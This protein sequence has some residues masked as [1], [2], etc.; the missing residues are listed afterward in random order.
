MEFYTNVLQWGN[1]ILYRGIKDNRRILEKVPFGP[2]LFFKSQAQESEHGSLFGEPLEPIKFGDI[3]DAKEYLKKYG[4]VQGFPIFGNTNFAYQFISEKYKKNIEF[5]QSKIKIRTID[6]ETSTE[7]GFPDVRN[8]AEEILLI[9]IQDYYTKELITY[10]VKPTKTE[11]TRYIACKDERDLLNRFINDFQADYP[12]VI[13]GWNIE[14]FDLP[15]LVARITKILGEN[16]ARKLSPWNLIKEKEVNRGGRNDLQYDLVGI[17]VLDY[18]NLYKKFTYN[19]QESYTL[20]HI[21]YVE[22]T[23]RKLENPFDTFKEFYTNDW[24]RF[25]SYNVHDVRLVDKLEDKMKLIE[26][27][28]IMAFDAKCNFNDVFSAVKTWDCILYNELLKRKIVV[29]QKPK[30]VAG[31]IVGGYVKEPIPGKY[32]WVVAFDATSLYPSIIMEW[33]MSPETIRDDFI[34]L[35]MES[36]LNKSADLSGIDGAVAANGHVFSREYKG[37]FAEVV[38]R[39]FDDRQKYKKLMLQSQAGLELIEREIELRSKNQK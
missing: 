19:A 24:D 23:E 9:T 4:D 1:N 32:D 22:L 15:Y 34:S 11:E 33:N 2:T 5:D 12:D 26:L 38:Q 25:V 10:G 8:P 37:F 35:S 13:T 30:G 17:S 3:N 21:A 20:N 14:F 29:H 27:I 36:L 39:L 7:E 28:I 18:L 31:T 6:I 16:T